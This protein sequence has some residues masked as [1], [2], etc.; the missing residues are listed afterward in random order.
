MI[1]PLASNAL[2]RD[3]KTQYIELLKTKAI[4]NGK[5]RTYL[6]LIIQGVRDADFR[7]NGIYAVDGHCKD[8]A[9]EECPEEEKVYNDIPEWIIG[10]HGYNPEN[11]KGFYSN[12]E[13]N[14]LNI[15]INNGLLK[16]FY[17]P[18]TERLKK[19]L[20]CQKEDR[21]CFIEKLRSIA[22]KSNAATMAE[23]FWERAY[24]GWESNHPADAM[25][26][27]GIAIHLVQDA[28]IPYHT[29]LLRNEI[30]KNHNQYEKYVWETYLGKGNLNVKIEGN[31]KEYSPE[32][33]VK[34]NAEESSKYNL[35]PEISAADSVRLG[36]SSTAGMI[37]N[38]FNLVKAVKTEE[39]VSSIKM[40]DE[41][42]NKEKEK[43]EATMRDIV[44]IANAL[45]EYIADSDI[46]PSYEGK[47]SPS[48]SIY[49][50]LSP[51]YVMVLPIKDAWGNPFYIISGKPGIK[52][53]LIISLGIDGIMENNPAS[54]FY[55]CTRLS[56]F[57][58]DIIIKNGS[59]IRGP[60]SILEIIKEKAN[61]SQIVIS[62]DGVKYSYPSWSPDGQKI[63]FNSYYYEKGLVR[64]YKGK[65]E[66]SESIQRGDIYTI[67]PDGSNKML[68]SRKEGRENSKPLWSPEGKLI[69]FRRTFSNGENDKG[70]EVSCEISCPSTVYL[71]KLDGTIIGEIPSKW[72]IYDYIWSPDGRKILYT[73]GGKETEG[74]GVPRIWIMNSDGT[75]NCLISDEESIRKGIYINPCWSP[76]GLKIAYI[77]SSRGIKESTLV[78]VDV[79]S[80]KKIEVATIEN[81]DRYS[82]FQIRFVDNYRVAVPLDNNNLC[83]VP[84]DGKKEKTIINLGEGKRYSWSSDNSKI[85]Y[86]YQGNIWIMNYDAT[87]K[88]QLT[89]SGV[90]DKA[91]SFSISPLRNKILFEKAGTI[92]L[93]DLT[94]EKN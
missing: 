45:G 29:K 89:T 67:S 17:D 28:T 33:W 80:M 88:R 38:F 82:D 86:L 43:Q 78:I 25:Y 52:D 2:A 63:I 19:A 9:E 60:I 27:L 56:D 50:L 64:T 46:A 66:P 21:V 58:K 4:V 47:L 53:F 42:L 31:Y 26:N 11:G 87:D 32:E 12:P 79:Q 73:D 24:I 1:D 70:E 76:E 59:W 41:L 49:P 62:T 5:E 35:S 68:L 37:V 54:E 22:L 34:K 93:L 36:V 94:N 55:S 20:G 14:F 83:F 85:I 71:M 65:W 90:F 6:D 91:Q 75:N 39:N 3:G 15:R 74:Y 57:N 84:I 16:N 23:F 92:C 48:C 81:V 77:R 13:D 61:I 72:S 10:D 40:V 8:P 69:M 30:D 7:V 51:F 18:K 44:I